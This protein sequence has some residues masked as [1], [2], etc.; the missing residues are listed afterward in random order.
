MNNNEKTDLNTS[1]FPELTE[2]K[3]LY[4]TNSVYLLFI[5][6]IYIIYI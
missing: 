5:F 3:I 6:S 2:L 4:V 1:H